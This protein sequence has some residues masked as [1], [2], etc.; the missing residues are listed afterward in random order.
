MF[1]EKGREVDGSFT[2]ANNGFFEFEGHTVDNMPHGAGTLHLQ[3]GSSVTGTFVRGCLEGPGVRRWQNGSIYCGLF[4]QGEYHGAGRLIDAAKGLDLEGEFCYGQLKGLGIASDSRRRHRYEGQF[5]GNL[6]H[7]KGLLRAPSSDGSNG[8]DLVEGDFRDGHPNGHISCHFA[9][10]D[11]YTGAVVCGMLHGEGELV[12]KESG[13]T[14]RG[15]LIKGKCSLPA[16]GFVVTSVRLVTGSDEGEESAELLPTAPGD[17]G[18]WAVVLPA[19]KLVAVQLKLGLRETQIELK[20]PPPKMDKDRKS[21]KSDKSGPKVEPSAAPIE[22]RTHR[23][24]PY[25]CESGRAVQF[26]A[27]SA[28]P[29]IVTLSP[30]GGGLD[31]IPP[32][33]VP[34]VLTTSLNAKSRTINSEFSSGVAMFEFSSFP[35]IGDYVLRFSVPNAAVAKEPGR[36]SGRMP[37]AECFLLVRVR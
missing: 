16:T 35:T 4:A 32:G 1:P 21:S 28:P 23:F 33:L 3:D 25:S 11:V 2:F 29:G 10:G 22:L 20:S 30:A 19:K 9:N 36:S 14:Y 37:Y 7:G 24:A 27:F 5:E 12:H 18:S 15:Q 8:V 17:D 26:E 34:S 6:F 13:T 31:S